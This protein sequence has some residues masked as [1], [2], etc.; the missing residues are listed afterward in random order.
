MIRILHKAHAQPARADMAVSE[1]P[2]LL[3]A[4]HDHR[5]ML[6]VDLFGDAPTPGNHGESSV[7]PAIN[8]LLREVF[9]FDPLAVDDA[10]SETH[11]PKVDDW[12]HYLY[13]VLHAVVFKSDIAQ[14]DTRELDVFLGHKLLVTYHF[15]PIPALEL[16]WKQAQ[17][18][19][20]YWKRGAD[21]LLYE[22]YD[23]IAT[24][25]MPCLD[26]IEEVTDQ[27]QDAIFDAP[28]PEQVTR[29]L[30]VKRA[31]LRL[32][33][34]LSPQREVVNKLARDSYGMVDS[35]NRVYFR[36]VYDH[37]VRLADLNE[38]VRDLV[39]GA[40]DS[41]LSVIANRTNEVMKVLTVVTTLFMPLTFITGFFGM[42]FFGAA[43][44]VTQAPLGWTLLG[45][46]LLGMVAT[47]LAMFGYMRQ[48]RWL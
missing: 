6:W 45:L 43:L 29:I 28:A 46:A 1:L 32:R 11:V 23:R 39:T 42:N 13:I 12:A 35:K 4:D 36:D 16:V 41:Y 27:I 18:D 48:R 25:Y 37:F 24:D 3:A 19:D 2:A 10:L 7:D 44:D 38:S 9:A 17:R 15:E 14:I 8:H 30:H 47:P 34:I 22:L 31:V 20:R 26:E 5:A 21:Y 40:L 33:R